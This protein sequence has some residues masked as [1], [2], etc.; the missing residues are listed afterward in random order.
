MGKLKCIGGVQAAKL[1]R[2]RAGLVEG[3]ALGMCRGD[4]LYV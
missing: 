1:G 3:A 4:F 2:G